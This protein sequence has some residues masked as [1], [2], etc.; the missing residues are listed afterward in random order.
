MGVKERALAGALGGFGGTFVL[1]G[2]R[3]ALASIGAVFTTAPEQVVA[4]A[5]EL[6]LLD[7]FSPA[8]RK[9]LVVAAHFA[10][11]TGA[12]AIF[13]ARAPRGRSQ[14]PRAHKEREGSRAR[15]PDTERALRAGGVLTD[16]IAPPPGEFLSETNDNSVTI[17]VTHGTAALLSAVVA[18]AEEEQY[19]ALNGY[20]RSE[21]TH[22]A[23][24]PRPAD[25]G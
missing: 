2:L 25:R 10:Y 23:K 19:E 14:E 6:G 4:R 7:R 11:S 24:V 22:R 17:L 21:T 9:A 15:R 16:L 18:R 12:G 1:S 13:G 5:E 8:A 3:W 20:Q